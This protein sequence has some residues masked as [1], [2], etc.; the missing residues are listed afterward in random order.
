MSEV[1]EIIDNKALNEAEKNESEKI[2]EE[3]IAEEQNEEVQVDT[4]S[5][6][7]RDEF[8]S[9]RFKIEIQNLPKHFG[10]AVGL[11]S[12]IYNLNNLHVDSLKQLKKY[13]TSLKLEYVKVK[14][15]GRCSYAFVTFRNEEAKQDAMKIINESTF[16]GKKLKAIVS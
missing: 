4:D 5:Y 8:T 2:D 15:P 16:K 14:S 6:L 11:S 10:F 1:V 13:L 9:E 7:N 12:W 3:N